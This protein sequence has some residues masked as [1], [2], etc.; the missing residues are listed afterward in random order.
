MF[1]DVNFFPAL[2]MERKYVSGTIP[3][4][5]D[6]SRAGGFRYENLHASEHTFES[7]L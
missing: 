5:R 1:T 2:E 6:R 4:E 7:S 3:A